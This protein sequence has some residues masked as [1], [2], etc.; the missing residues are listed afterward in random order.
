LA[1]EHRTARLHDFSQA[2]GQPS[3]REAVVRREPRGA[4]AQEL[5]KMSSK[6]LDRLAIMRRVVEGRLPQAKAAKPCPIASAR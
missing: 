6:E 3:V 1:L 2:A 5:I 4:V